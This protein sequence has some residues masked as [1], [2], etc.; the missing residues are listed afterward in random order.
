MYFREHV[1][2]IL[3][4]DDTVPVDR[5][6]IDVAHDTAGRASNLKGLRIFHGARVVGEVDF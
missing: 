2:D 5:I 3:P 1:H 4:Q 6:D